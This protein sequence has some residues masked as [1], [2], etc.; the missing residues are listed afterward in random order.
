MVIFIF[1]TSCAQPI[2]NLLIGVI[3]DIKS[4]YCNFFSNF[5]EI[6]YLWYFKYGEYN[7][8]ICISNFLCPGYDKVI[9]AS[10]T[11]ITTHQ[12]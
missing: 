3:S 7:G 6:F 4:Q 9:G 10:R 12:I 1:Q 2:I 5:N 8:N 11:V